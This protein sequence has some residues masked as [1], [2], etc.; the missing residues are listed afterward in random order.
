MQRVHIQPVTSFLMLETQPNFEQYDQS[1]NYS[2]VP[3]SFNKT[4]L[5]F[6]INRDANS[7]C[8]TVFPYTL[9]R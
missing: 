5:S 3:V 4:F 7:S 6:S 8:W 2:I 9:N 1:W